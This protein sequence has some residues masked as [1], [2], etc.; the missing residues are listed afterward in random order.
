MECKSIPGIKVPEIPR[1]FLGRL[2]PRPA[3]A[4]QRAYGRLIK[5]RG[6]FNQDAEVIPELGIIISCDT[7]LICNANFGFINIE[8]LRGKVKGNSYQIGLRDSCS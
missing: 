6:R 3:R 1:R 5:S 7:F 2:A 8:K 4:G